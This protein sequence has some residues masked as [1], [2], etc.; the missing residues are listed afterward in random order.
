M[1]SIFEKMFGKSVKEIREKNIARQESISRVRK[2]KEA[3]EKGTHPADVDKEA[4]KLSEELEVSYEDAAEYVKDEKKSA[5][6][7]ES[8]QKVVGLLGQIGQRAKEDTA[9]R[10]HQPVAMPVMK[11]FPDIVPKKR[12]LNR[13]YMKKR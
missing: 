12:I 13:Q 5:A 11:K 6:R 2:L 10:Y 4:K 9:R 1:P 3:K 7:K 8:F